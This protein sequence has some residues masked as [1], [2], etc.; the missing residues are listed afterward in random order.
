MADENIVSKDG[1]F[2]L[3]S[4]APDVCITP[5]K[6]GSPVPY[7]ITHTMDQSQ[8]C[9]PNVFLQ[10]K[11]VYLHNESYVDNVKGDE[12]GSGG[13]VITRVHMKVSHSKQH[14]RNVY[15]NGHAVVR[16]DDQMHMNTKKP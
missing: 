5:S 16:P 11:P 9:S 1:R 15:V 12:P 6:K 13:G 2:R 4:L 14:S 8:Q 10:G 3:V 7:P